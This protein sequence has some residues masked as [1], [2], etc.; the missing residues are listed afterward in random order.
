MALI[1]CLSLLIYSAFFVDY[2]S[3]HYIML[4]KHT[5]LLNCFESLFLLATIN[6]SKLVWYGMAPEQIVTNN[7]LTYQP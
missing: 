6:L 1:N 3:R 2:S 4:M 5:N 7:S